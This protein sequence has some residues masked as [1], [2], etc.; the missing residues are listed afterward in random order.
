MLEVTIEGADELQRAMQRMPKN[1]RD[2]AQKTVE[3]A[4]NVALN[5]A[6][7]TVPVR[8][9]NLKNSLN[10]KT[11]NLKVEVTAS[12]P[13]A[14]YVEYGTRFARAQ[15]FMRL[16]AAEAESIII[17]DFIERIREAWDAFI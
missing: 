15:P 9:G 10:V 11:A 3:K 7:S 13:Y 8:T 1:V 12:A 16:G 14:S 5:K 2:A 17:N 6:Q 4:G